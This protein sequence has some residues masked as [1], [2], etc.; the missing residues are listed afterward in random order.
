[1][2][3][4]IRGQLNSI[5][6]RAHMWIVNSSSIR[7]ATQYK[8]VIR[9]MIFT[10]MND[11]DRRYEWSIECYDMTPIKSVPRQN[12]RVAIRYMDEDRTE[13]ILYRHMYPVYF[14]G[15]WF[16]NGRIGV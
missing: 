5:I 14:T 15:A 8:H 6:N 9:S 4:S 13:K 12:V 10:Y 16:D 1:M 7:R 11:W 2:N 3:T